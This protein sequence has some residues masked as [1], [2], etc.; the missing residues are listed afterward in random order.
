MR[1]WWQKWKMTQIDISYSWI[2]SISL[3]KMT[4]LS[5]AIC[6]FNAIPV[7][8]PVVCFTELEYNILMSVWRHQRLNGQT[9]LRKKNK[10]RVL[11][12]SV[13]KLLLYKATIRK[14]LCHWH[15][16][17]NIEQWNRT[18]SPEINSCTDDQQTKRRNYIQ[19]RKTV[20][21]IN[22]AGTVGQQVHVRI[23]TRILFNIIQINK[24]KM[25]WRPKCKAK[26]YNTQCKT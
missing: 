18:E 3:I 12:L 10:A 15:K 2:G 25:N 13:F 17:W 21:S 24:C 11:R 20:S 7:K 1:H 22:S 4:I 5:K 26:F 6:R 8:L 9:I 16:N 14:I 19:C 23:E